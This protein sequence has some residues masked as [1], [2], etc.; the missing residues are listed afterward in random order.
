VRYWQ[1][2]KAWSELMGQFKP[3]NS[4]LQP[5]QLENYKRAEKVEAPWI[6]AS[7]SN[8]FG[9]QLVPSIG[10]SSCFLTL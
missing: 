10:V 1:Q 5:Q 6:A 4:A 2:D 8:I 9:G 3:L 7:G